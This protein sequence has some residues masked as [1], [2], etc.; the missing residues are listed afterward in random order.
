LYLNNSGFELLC[1]SLTTKATASQ[2]PEY[3]KKIPE[4]PGEAL[5]EDYSSE[6]SLLYYLVL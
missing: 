6:K 4:E 1:Y 3:T 5:V 2:C